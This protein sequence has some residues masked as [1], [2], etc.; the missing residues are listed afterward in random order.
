[1]RSRVICEESK[2]AW[3]GYAQERRTTQRRGVSG[4]RRAAGG[5]QEHPLPAEPGQL[6]A[7]ESPTKLAQDHNRNLAAFQT[8]ASLTA[9]RKDY[10]PQPASGS[11][12]IVSSR[13]RPGGG[14]IRLNK[15]L[16]IGDRVVIISP[17]SANQSDGVVHLRV[18]PPLCRLRFAA[19]LRCLASGRSEL[20]RRTRSVVSATP[21]HSLC[22]AAIWAMPS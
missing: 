16:K 13:V 17:K 21:C 2:R 4:L 12:L 8:A 1:M 15:I 3:L 20:S 18:Q 10:S 11:P 22:G 6:L 5:G 19:A 14:R 9:S 7:Y